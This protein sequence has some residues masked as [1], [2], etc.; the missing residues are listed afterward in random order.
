MEHKN[1]IDYS[2]PAPKRNLTEKLLHVLCIV[3]MAVLTGAVY[4]GLVMRGVL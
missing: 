3:A 4:V 2:Q 1:L